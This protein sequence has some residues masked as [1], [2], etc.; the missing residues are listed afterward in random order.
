MDALKE[1]SKIVNI[2]PD[3]LNTRGMLAFL[4][5]EI[6]LSEMEIA[7]LR[8]KYDVAT[9]DDLYKLIASKAINSHPAWEDYINWKNKDKYREE[10]EKKIKLIR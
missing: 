7:D 3:E 6:R 2:P 1:V 4:E 5:K 9:K 10:L 8:E